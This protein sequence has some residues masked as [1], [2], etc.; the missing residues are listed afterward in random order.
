MSVP[1]A[2]LTVM[3]VWS[4]TPLAIAWSSQGLGP[5]W[6]V[7]A[8]MAI[9]LAFC[10]ALLALLRRRLPMDR[11]AWR[12]YGVAGAGIFGAMGLSYLGALHVPSGWIAVVF[13]LSPVFT[14]LM[15]ARW[16]GEPLGGANQW[17]GLGLG[18]AGVALLHLESGGAREVAWGLACLLAAVA[19]H[20]GSG[21]WVKR[22]GRSR[23][24][25]PLSLVTGALAVSVVLFG[26]SAWATATPWPD[27]VTPQALGAVV[28]LGLFGSVLGFVAY[29]YVLAR[30]SA[31]A[32]SLITLVTPVLALG[33]GHALN[34]EPLG[35]RVLGGA[36]L[37]L[38]GLA[39]Y[40]G[41]PPVF[42]FSR[43]SG[44]RPP[45]ARAGR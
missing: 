26:A 19:I 28:Y 29:Y 21:V 23:P 24:L 36:A 38:M 39:L 27:A 30:I 20:T 12:I 25:D 44:T 32:V 10:L 16:L 1:A 13:A 31:T 4:T 11:A 14:R 2:Y 37:V 43:R 42:R 6:G 33:L 41:A 40:Q 9:G 45:R 5:L 3:L 22:L 7:E 15:S 35:P 34:G 17:A 18:L 8:R